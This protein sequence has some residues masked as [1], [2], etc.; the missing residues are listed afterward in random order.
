MYT[1]IRKGRLLAGISGFG[2]LAALMTA[3]PPKDVIIDISEDGVDK[4][5]EA[6]APCSG[7]SCCDGDCC[8][9]IV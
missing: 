3:C 5:I 9:Y 2:V 8:G 1:Y 7:G 4:L 6:C